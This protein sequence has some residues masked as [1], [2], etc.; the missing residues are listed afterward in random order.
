M[1]EEKPLKVTYTL[2]TIYGNVEPDPHLIHKSI[3]IFDPLTPS[4]VDDRH[5]SNQTTT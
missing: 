5:K 3:E 2:E 1:E 4:P